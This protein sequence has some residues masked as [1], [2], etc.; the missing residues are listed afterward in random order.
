MAFETSRSVLCLFAT[1][2]K[3]RHGFAKR[4]KKFPKVQTGLGFFSETCGQ[5]FEV[6]VQRNEFAPPT[7]PRLNLANALPGVA[8]LRPG[9]SDLHLQPVNVLHI[10]RVSAP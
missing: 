3:Q 2:S 1:H 5:W 6:R 4:V 9:D 7:P 8:E 10:Q